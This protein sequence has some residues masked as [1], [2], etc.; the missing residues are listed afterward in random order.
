[1]AIANRA[2]TRQA[3]KSVVLPAMRNGTLLCNAA[4]QSQALAE[5][6]INSQ[7]RGWL[8]RDGDHAGQDNHYSERGRAAQQMSMTADVAFG[9]CVTSNAGPHGERNCTR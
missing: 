7:P 8:P 9:S 1:M 5:R 3:C 6:A 4:M 2:T